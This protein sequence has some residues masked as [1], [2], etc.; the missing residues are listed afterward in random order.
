M[1]K[2]KSIAAKGPKPDNSFGLLVPK[3]AFSAT[4]DHLFPIACQTCSGASGWEIA[5][6][7]SVLL[8]QHG[9]EQWPNPSKHPIGSFPP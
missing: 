9:K 2:G 1:A 3:L 7:G 8:P 5:P 4:K 6:T